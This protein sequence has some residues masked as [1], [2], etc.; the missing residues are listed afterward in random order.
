V[1][2]HQREKGEGSGEP[3][4]TSFLPFLFYPMAKNILTHV[5]Q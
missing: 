4:M 3:C 1:V 2:R 5:D